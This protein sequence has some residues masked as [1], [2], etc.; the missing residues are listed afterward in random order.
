MAF[1]GPK[2]FEDDTALDWISELTDSDDPRNFLIDS[3]TTKSSEL[4][5]EQCATILAAAE[6]IV[7]VLDEPRAGL[8]DELLDWVDENDCDDIS[9]L[10]ST[11]LKSVKRVLGSGSEL[12]EA[13]EDGD[14]YDDWRSE[15]EGLRDI[16]EQLS[17]V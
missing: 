12:R 4:D 11:A 9:D 16:L 14:G 3:V 17:Q 13:W 5:L 8:P 15:V 7:A 6:T 1:W 2:T 10:P